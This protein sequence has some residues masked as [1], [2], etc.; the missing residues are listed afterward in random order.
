MSLLSEILRCVLCCEEDDRGHV[1]NY[2]LLGQWGLEWI[3]SVGNGLNW[4]GME[5]TRYVYVCN[6]NFTF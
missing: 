3:G 1:D 4:T 5:I 6:Y 2:F